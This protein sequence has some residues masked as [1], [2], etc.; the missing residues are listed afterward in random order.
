MMATTIV[1]IAR[2]THSSMRLASKYLR[3][4]ARPCGVAYRKS[5]TRLL[6]IERFSGAYVYMCQYLS[7]PGFEGCYYHVWSRFRTEPYR[8]T[9]VPQG[10]PLI[11][12]VIT[13]APIPIV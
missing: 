12:W 9:R 13:M 4:L 11:S 6:N 8:H 7:H 2:T 5:L 10:L 3:D 1:Y